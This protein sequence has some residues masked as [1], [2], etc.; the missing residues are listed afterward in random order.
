MKLILETERFIL[1]EIGNSDA[2]ALFKMDSDPQVMRYLGQKPL[3]EIAQTYAYINDLQQQYDQTGIGRWAVI[4]KEDQKLVGWCGLKKIKEM[5]GH[6]DITELGYRFLAE[7]WGKG[8]ATETALACLNYGF[9]T[10]NIKTIYA[11]ADVEN[12]ASNKI[13]EH[14]LGFENRGTFVDPQDMAS[15]YWYELIAAKFLN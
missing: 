11:I 6:F 1:R 2:E 7:T 10:L 14:K 13:L 12:L 9:N 5:N 15:C 4:R 3:M 8:S